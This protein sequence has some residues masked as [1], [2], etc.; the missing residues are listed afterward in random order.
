MLDS[1][2]IE[3]LIGPSVN[4]AKDTGRRSGDRRG[5]E[6][7]R[8]DEARRSV[9]TNQGIRP[10]PPIERKAFAHMVYFTLKEKTDELREKLLDGCDKYLTDHEGAIPLEH[11]H[12]GHRLSTACE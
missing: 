7:C 6:P 9:A 11:R 10:M 3:D 5:H 12:E 4:D 8:A 2:E 1:D